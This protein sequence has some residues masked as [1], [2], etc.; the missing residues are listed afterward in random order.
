MQ[1]ARDGIAVEWPARRAEAEF[2][3]LLALL[4]APAK[5]AAPNPLARSG[6]EQAHAQPH[7]QHA[8]M[9]GNHQGDQDLGLAE[10][11][12]HGG[13]KQETWTILRPHPATVQLLPRA[14]HSS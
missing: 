11:G 13:R 14:C 7:R 5:G 8:G 3:T 10:G 1:R 4:G 12:N 9:G 6:L 2:P